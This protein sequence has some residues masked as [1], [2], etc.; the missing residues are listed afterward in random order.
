MPQ[1]PTVADVIPNY[2]AYSWYG[3]VAPRDTPVE[4]VSVLDRGIN[5][6]LTDAG[7]EA[8]LSRLGGTALGGSSVD[9]GRLIENETDKWGRIIR[10][11]HIKL[12]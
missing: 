10:G 8:H 7:F 12:G 11:A 6:A 1:V 5:S 3:I 4:I 2:E 9:F